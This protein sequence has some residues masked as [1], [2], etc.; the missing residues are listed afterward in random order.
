[1]PV[2][3]RPSPRPMAR[4]F[5]GPH[6]ARPRAPT[7]PRPRTRRS[8]T[9]RAP[10]AV[11]ADSR[12]PPPRPAGR[13]R[14]H[15]A[16]RRSRTRAA[17]PNT[18][19]RHRPETHAPRSPLRTR[20]HPA[21]PRAS[22]TPNPGEPQI[23]GDRAPRRG[24]RRDLD[25]G[26]SSH[27]RRL[28]LVR[29]LGLDRHEPSVDRLDH[30]Q[31]I[32]RDRDDQPRRVVELPTVGA[33]EVSPHAALGQRHRDGQP[34]PGRVLADLSDDRHRV[35]AGPELLSSEVRVD[36]GPHV[37]RA[38]AMLGRRPLQTDPL[39]HR[40]RSEQ[41]DPGCPRDQ[42]PDQCSRVTARGRSTSPPGQR[43]AGPRAPPRSAPAE[44]S[45]PACRSCSR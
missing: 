40:W 15:R 35:D 10:A 13:P 36:R 22:R 34:P 6:R 9:P 24:R 33:H 21:P 30:A 2:P 3:G 11:V 42:Q 43:L 20:P 31:R 1:M 27:R 12:G 29:L 5:A 7:R 32:Q 23:H 41:G 25:R 4:C 19:R 26:R 44:P 39:P 38:G 37:R 14:P 18:A 45:R 8:S 28:R 17:A 16:R